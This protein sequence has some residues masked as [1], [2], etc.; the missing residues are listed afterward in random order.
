MPVRSGAGALLFLVGA[1]QKGIV[2][3]HR[4]SDTKA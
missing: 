2:V 1:E 4:P 3:N